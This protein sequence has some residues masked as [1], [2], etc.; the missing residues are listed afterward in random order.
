MTTTGITSKQ[1][2][3]TMKQKTKKK[4]QLNESEEK[5]TW[6]T[7]QQTA[8]KSRSV[9]NQTKTKSVPAIQTTCWVLN[10]TFRFALQWQKTQE[11]EMERTKTVLANERGNIVSNPLSTS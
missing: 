2:H 8:E 5:K 6:W 10:F 11:R 1:K 7:E 3:Q 9:P 4:T